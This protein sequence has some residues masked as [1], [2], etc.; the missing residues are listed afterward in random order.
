M[1]PRWQRILLLAFQ[2]IWLGAIVPG[3]TRGVVTLPGTDACG[4][5]AP[6]TSKVRAC[7]VGK[8]QKSDGKQCP[9][10]DP[11]KR[12]SC[13]AVCFFAARLSTPPPIDFYP[14]PLELLERLSPERR[15]APVSLPLNLAY[16]ATG[17][18]AISVG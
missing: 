14:P 11:V 18:P 17:P 9:K 12:A 15:P 6:D 16:L 8:E 1:A 5:C 13:C 7:C 3:H 10:G 2:A 4:S